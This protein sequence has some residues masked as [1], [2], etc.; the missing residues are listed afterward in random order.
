VN[1]RFTLS[2][3]FGRRLL[4]IVGSMNFKRLVLHQL[5]LTNSIEPAKSVKTLEAETANKRQLLSIHYSFARGLQEK[6]AVAQVADLRSDR[7]RSSVHRRQDTALLDRELTR[8]ESL[9]NVSE[10]LLG[11]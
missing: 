3:R 11:V 1:S 7:Q 10:K 9:L 2:A 5:E 4:E 8:L 6:R